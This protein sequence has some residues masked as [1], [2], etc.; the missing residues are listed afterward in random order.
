MQEAKMSEKGEVISR[1]NGHHRNSF[2]R[3]KN[4]V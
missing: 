1:Q 2:P 4:A 3:P